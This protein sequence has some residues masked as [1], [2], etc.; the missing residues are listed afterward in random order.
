MDH[1]AGPTH[2]PASR[3]TEL[4]R[5]LLDAGKIRESRGCAM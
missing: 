3:H 5:A 2:A 1:H 4:D